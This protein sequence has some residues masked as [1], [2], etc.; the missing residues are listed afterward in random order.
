[1][2]YQYKSKRTYE[3]PLRGK[4]Q[5]IACRVVNRARRCFFSTQFT[6]FTR[7]KSTNADKAARKIACRVMGRARRCYFTCFLFTRFTSTKK[8]HILSKH[9]LA[10]DR[11]HAPLRRL[12]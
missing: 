4:K 7:K 10:R 2:P 5:N 1:L 8:L 9:R 6:C 3:A 11:P 12:Y